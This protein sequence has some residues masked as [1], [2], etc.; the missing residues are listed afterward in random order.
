MENLS[1]PSPQE[2]S[3]ANGSP[4]SLTMASYDFVPLATWIVSS[5]LL[6]KP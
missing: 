1:S 5:A 2:R 4:K 3:T 6:P